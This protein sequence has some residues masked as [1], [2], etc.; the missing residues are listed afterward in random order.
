MNEKTNKKG[1]A[2]I[3]V[4]LLS[5]MI[6]ILGMGLISISSSSYDIA[7]DETKNE[8]AYL[9]SKSGLNFFLNSLKDESSAEL[10]DLLDKV[11]TKDQSDTVTIN[12]EVG[13]VTINLSSVNDYKIQIDST[14]NIN[15]ISTITTAYLERTSS[16]LGFD[17]EDKPFYVL[18]SFVNEKV[19]N[20]NIKYGSYKGTEI[21]NENAQNSVQSDFDDNYV[22]YKNEEPY[23]IVEDNSINLTTSIYNSIIKLQDEFPSLPTPGENACILKTSPMDSIDKIDDKDYANEVKYHNC[24]LNSSIIPTKKDGDIEKYTI[25]FDSIFFE[26]RSDKMINQ[27]L[28]YV[29]SMESLS[30]NLSIYGDNFYL[31]DIVYLSL[32]NPNDLSKISIKDDDSTGSFK[33]SLDS[34]SYTPDGSNDSK[35]SYKYVNKDTFKDYND[36]ENNSL[37]N[38]AYGPSF[39]NTTYGNGQKIVYRQDG[40][41]SNNFIILIDNVDPEYSSVTEITL[42]TKLDAWIYAPNYTV[43]IEKDAELTGDVIAKKIIVDKDAKVD[44]VSLNQGFL[45]LIESDYVDVSWRVVYE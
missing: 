40:D 42:N 43:N 18:D 15:G 39:F 19:D 12:D 1:A 44:G 9:S 41:Q 35:E 26:N 11:K 21:G 20:S 7:V 28:I 6:I 5:A 30:S 36:L 27:N 2:L 4:V 32:S 45:D 8:Q 22:D 3:Y 31:Q 10:Q 29:K 16:L 24:V 37:I 14:S 23:S 25:G 17:F 33:F 34:L 13:D 38:E